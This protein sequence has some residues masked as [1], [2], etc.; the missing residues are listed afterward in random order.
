MD[1][2]TGN[3]YLLYCPISCESQ[4]DNWLLDIELY[5]EEFRAD[6]VSMWMDEMGVAQTP[7]LRKGFQTVQ[8]VL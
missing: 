2:T 7:A 3:G 8:K 1:D 4:E 6:M 5:S